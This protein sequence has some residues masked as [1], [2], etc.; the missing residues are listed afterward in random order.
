MVESGVDNV[1]SYFHT[2]YE[3]TVSPVWNPKVPA[4]IPSVYLSSLTVAS[5][6]TN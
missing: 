6:Q 2:R 3:C 4:L 5:F 1:F